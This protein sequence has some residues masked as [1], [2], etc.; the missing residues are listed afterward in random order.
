MRAFLTLLLPF[1]FAC[2]QQPLSRSGPTEAVFDA[3]PEDNPPFRFLAQTFVLTPTELIPLDYHQDRLP[4]DAYY[5]QHFT[6]DSSKTSHVYF[7]DTRKPEYR[8]RLVPTAQKNHY[9]M[10][11]L[12]DE[13]YK[14]VSTLEW[15]LRCR[16]N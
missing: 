4:I 2:S 14:P 1:L 5:P 9:K 11:M 7:F 16:S 15:D 13:S 8:F 3:N 12:I 10:Q 6:R